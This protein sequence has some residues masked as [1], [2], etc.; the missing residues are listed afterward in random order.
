MTTKCE[1]T[2]IQLAPVRIQSWLRAHA[3]RPGL[4]EEP[5]RALEV[6]EVAGVLEREPGLAVHEAADEP[7]GVVGAR[8]EGQLAQCVEPAVREPA[9]AQTPDPGQLHEQRMGPGH[10]RQA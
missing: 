4:E 6:H 8:E 2:Y 7:V 3:W 5:E 1:F 9:T 10:G